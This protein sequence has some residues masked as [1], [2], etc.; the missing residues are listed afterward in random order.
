MPYIINNTRGNLVATVADGTV[1]ISTIP[2]ALVGRGLTPYGL[3]ENENYVYLLENFCNPTAPVNPMQGQLWFDSANTLL[4]VFSVANAWVAL[5][6]QSYVQEQKISPI[7]TGV[8]SAPTA[9]SG[10]NTTQL[11][12]TAF[13]HSA[14]TGNISCVNLVTQNNGNITADLTVGGNLNVNGATNLN[15]LTV[16]GAASLASL[17]VT[18]AASLTS[19]SVSGNIS[20]GSIT[21]PPGGTLGNITVQNILNAN[22][23]GTGNIGN[24]SVYFN[25]VFAKSTSAQYA[26]L[27]EHYQGDGEYPAG[28]VVVFG[29]S[30]E[31]TVSDWDHDPRVA[32]VVSA[33]PAYVMNAQHAHTLVALQGRVMCRVQGP[34]SKGDRLVN[35]R[36]GVAGRLRSDQYQ[37]GCV[38]GK[39][40]VD[41]P[42]ADEVLVEVAVGRL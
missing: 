21:I 35:V 15:S 36:A 5:A 14:V 24:A 6:S 38:I 26:D 37:P 39:S 40:L 3:Y 17:S 31:I 34:V 18:G 29:G 13:V 19:L 27:A 10:T 30:A 33:N 28:T 16:S 11:A 22:G 42:T 1:D 41:V 12:T 2:V 25:T 23:N 32:G 4:S 8:P 7:F 9:V 20:A